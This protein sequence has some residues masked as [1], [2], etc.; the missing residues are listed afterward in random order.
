MRKKT[1][2]K[3]ARAAIEKEIRIFIFDASLFDRRLARTVSTKR[4]AKKVERLREAI[5]ILLVEG[6]LMSV[7]DPVLIQLR[8][9]GKKY[10]LTRGRETFYDPDNREIIEFDTVTEAR[11]WS[12]ATLGVDPAFGVNIDPLAEPLDKLPL[13][14]R[15]E[16]DEDVLNA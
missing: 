13:F 6:G 9:K 1:A 10:I 15:E 3:I 16:E 8:I 12:I 11:S 5:R 4:A 7:D 2:Y 14:A